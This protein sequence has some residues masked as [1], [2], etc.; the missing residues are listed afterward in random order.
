MPTMSQVM[1]RRGSCVDGHASPNGLLAY[2]GH[3]SGRM[4]LIERVDSRRSTGRGLLP[5]F[6]LSSATGCVNVLGCRPCR[7]LNEKQAYKETQLKGPECQKGNCEK[8]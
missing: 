2:L 7:P 6:A 5:N 3:D 1:G 4:G 8:T